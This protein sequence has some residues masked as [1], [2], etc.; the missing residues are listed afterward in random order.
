MESEI[1]TVY[2]F[3][4]ES[5]DADR[6]IGVLGVGSLWDTC[7][8]NSRSY[9]HKVFYYHPLKKK[10]MKI[11]CELRAE[12]ATSGFIR[13]ENHQWLLLV[14]SELHALQNNMLFYKTKYTWRTQ[15]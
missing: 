4:G 9:L 15:N 3:V 13:D 7:S 12:S 6:F 1:C 11:M 10:N 5:R 14:P 2:V 8:P